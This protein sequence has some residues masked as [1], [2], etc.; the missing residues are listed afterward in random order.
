MSESAADLAAMPWA[1][2]IARATQAWHRW[3]LLPDSARMDRVFKE[4]GVR[5]L[6]VER[7]ALLARCQEAER[8][9][10]TYKADR[11]SYDEVLGRRMAERDEWHNRAEAAE[12]ERDEARRDA[13]RWCDEC[14]SAEAR[15][16]QLEQALRGMMD[17]AAA[18]YR[19]PS[20][21]YDEYQGPM[22][23]A[24]AALGG[25]A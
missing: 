24:R 21:P 22:E 1:D 9:A 12:A 19:N 13:A 20:L 5:D 4:S 15:V 14:N 6:L 11:D 23:V 16:T 10:E 25:T 2:R 7:E 3:P 17:C 18:I 8:L